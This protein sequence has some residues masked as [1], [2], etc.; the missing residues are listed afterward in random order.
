M[1]VETTYVAGSGVL[2]GGGFHWLLLDNVPGAAVLDRW[3]SLIRTGVGVT[4]RLLS[5]LDRHYR[6]AQP[7]LVLVDL[8]PGQE[9]AELRGRGVV[10][11]QD[12]DRL[13]DVGRPGTGTAAVPRRHR[14]LRLGPPLA[15]RRT[16]HTA[17]PGRDHRGH[18]R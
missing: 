5:E 8:T 18:S 6:G 16:D 17:R 10:T 9:R 1:D 13:L 3:F 11:E 2:L 12:D 7:L 15:R 14:G 4:D